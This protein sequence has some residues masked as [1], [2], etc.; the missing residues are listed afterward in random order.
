[1]ELISVISVWKN[2]WAGSTLYDWLHG[3]RCYSCFFLSLFYTATWLN[4]NQYHS[5]FLFSEL[6]EHNSGLIE[7]RPSLLSLFRT[8]QCWTI[9]PI[10]IHAVLWRHTILSITATGFYSWFSSAAGTSMSWKACNE[11]QPL[12]ILDKSIAR[13]ILSGRHSGAVVPTVASQQKVLGVVF[14]MSLCL[15]EFVHSRLSGN[16]VGVNVSVFT[17]FVGPVID[18]QPVWGVHCP[19]SARTDSSLSTTLHG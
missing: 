6:C 12:E 1:M 19:L 15:W 2:G 8:C 7:S 10:I 9:K 17:L 14:T 5:L 4:P 18:W 13:Q 3:N 16:S 11:T